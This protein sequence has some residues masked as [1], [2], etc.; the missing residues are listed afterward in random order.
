MIKNRNFPSNNSY[1]A[2][3]E[4]PIIEIQQYLFDGLKGMDSE[5]YIEDNFVEKLID[6]NLKPFTYIKLRCFL[7]E[8]NK[9]FDFDCLYWKSS[10]NINVNYILYSIGNDYKIYHNEGTSRL[11]HNN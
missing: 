11:V 7:E 9:T 10:S 2:E 5:I 1:F 8:F 6:L 3:E 4:I